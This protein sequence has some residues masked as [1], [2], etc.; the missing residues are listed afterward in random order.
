M[1]IE[2]LKYEIFAEIFKTEDEAVLQMIKNI[3]QKVSSENELFNQL[4]RPKRNGMTVEDLIREQNY[5][6]FDREGFDKLVKE[7]DIQDPI[8][9]LLNSLT[10]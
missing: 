5:K 6:G 4:V 2:A 3:L 8:D 7:M 10:A 1:K 9:E